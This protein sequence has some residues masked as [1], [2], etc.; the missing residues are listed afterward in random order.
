MGLIGDWRR[1]ILGAGGVALLLPLGLTLGVA[2]TAA[3]GGETTLRALG[4]VIAGPGSV[5]GPAGEGL[6]SAARLPAV[7]VRARES[8]DGVMGGGSGAPTVVSDGDAA[9]GP[10]GGPGA[11]APTGPSSGPTPSGPSPSPSPAEPSQSPAAEP[12][13]APGS[14]AA[15]T[16]DEATGLLPAPLD[17]AAGSAVDTVV[18]LIP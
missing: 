12:G 14:A 15:E 13:P 8:R 1:S 16:A 9:P 10:A 6:E 7:P 17:D 18:D 2:L 4:Q 11:P 3:L 5:T